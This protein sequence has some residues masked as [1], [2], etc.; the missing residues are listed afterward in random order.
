[1]KAVRRAARIQVSRHRS[2]LHKLT[3]IFS[4]IPADIETLNPASRAPSRSTPYEPRITD[5][6]TAIAEHVQLEDNIQINCDRSGLKSNIGTVAVLFRTGSCPRTLRFHLSKD[7]EHTV[8]EAEEVGL[9]LAAQLL[10]MEEDLEFPISISID[11]QVALRASENL[12]P[13][14][15]SYIAEYF[16]RQMQAIVKNHRNFKV[17]LKWSP[18]HE[19]I[20]GNKMMD[21][22]VKLAATSRTNNSSC[23]DLPK[24][25]R[26]RTLPLSTSALIQAQR[27]ATLTRWGRMWAKSPRYNCIQ[28]IDPNVLQC[29][30]VKLTVSYPKKLT[31]LLICL[32]SQ[33]TPLNKHLHHI[34]KA[35]DP[36]CLHCP[37]QEETVQ[38]FLTTYPQYQLQRHAIQGALERDTSSIPH[39]VQYINATCRLKFIFGV[40]SLSKKNN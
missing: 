25:L 2:S 29:A 31:G 37:D 40:V 20:H 30:F 34:N 22:E 1:M 4:I 8:F 11:N 5:R 14:P 17:V 24:Y 28:N 7:E 27:Q 23:E 9:T 18:G 33:H 26:H 3:C 21:K 39:L 13:R 15:G 12:Q 10:K 19:G 36:N 32:R 35:E 16:N 6:E 38:H